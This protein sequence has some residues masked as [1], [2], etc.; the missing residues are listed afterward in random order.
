[1]HIHT[2]THTPC[3]YLRFDSCNAGE[4]AAPVNLQAIAQL[5]SLPLYEVHPPAE[6]SLPDT[7]A[8]ST[9]AP[10]SPGPL[11]TTATAAAANSTLSASPAAVAP[12]VSVSVGAGS[13]F[14]AMPPPRFVTLQPQSAKDSGPLLAPAGID[15]R[16]LG[17]A[18]L[19]PESSAEEQASL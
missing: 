5:Q 16:L 8:A 3:P 18:F 7:T 4:G 9:A 1:M 11:P 12:V 6:L 13:A 15:T 10:P 19:K 14:A 17:P 2:L